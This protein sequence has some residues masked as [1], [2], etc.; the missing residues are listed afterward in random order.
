M[1]RAYSFASVGWVMF[2]SCTVVSMMTSS[3]SRAFLSWMAMV[4]AST[5]SMPLS[6]MRLR[7]CTMSEGATGGFHWNTVSPVKYW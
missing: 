2:F 1:M 3:S 6:P 4:A 7:K 5:R